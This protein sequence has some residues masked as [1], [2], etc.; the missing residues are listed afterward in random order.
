[1]IKKHFFSKNQIEKIVKYKFKKIS[2]LNEALTH[3][4]FSKTDKKEQKNNQRMEFLGD[5]VLELIVNDYIY[6]KYPDFSEGEMTK[7]KSFIVSKPILKKWADEIDLGNYIILGKG[8]DVTGG[9]KKSSIL[10]GCFEALLGA[11][12]LDGGYRSARQYVLRFLINELSE[13]IKE[14]FVKNYKSLLQEIAQKKYKCLPDYELIKENGPDHKKYFS[15][16]VKIKEK[17]YGSGFGDNK[18]EA[19]QN[20]AQDTLKK[21]NIIE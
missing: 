15:V 19:E 16:H 12:Y 2:L 8:E 5:S 20:A 4:S 1:M 10:A 21:L 13:V 17:V 11:I 7:I 18:K 3:S 9:R 14:D 6:R